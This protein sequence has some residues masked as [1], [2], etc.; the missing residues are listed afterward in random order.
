M[1]ETIDDLL[2]ELEDWLKKARDLVDDGNTGAAEPF[3]HQSQSHVATVLDKL[4]ADPET[5][6]FYLGADEISLSKATVY[7]QFSY[8]LAN[9]ARAEWQNVKPSK[10]QVRLYMEILAIILPRYEKE[11]QGGGFGK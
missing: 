8:K 7:A 3:V 4:K 5:E 2:H 6:D 10:G 1:T 9:S 11:L